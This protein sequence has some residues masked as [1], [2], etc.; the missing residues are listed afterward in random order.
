MV[1]IVIISA[2]NTLAYYFDIKKLGHGQES[3]NPDPESKML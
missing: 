1:T 2:E 3:K